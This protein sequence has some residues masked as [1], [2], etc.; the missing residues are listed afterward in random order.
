MFSTQVLTV[1]LAP[2]MFGLWAVAEPAMLVIFGPNWAYA[3]PVLGLLALS[4]AILTPCSTFI[5]YLK[6]AGYGRVLFWSAT[7]RALVTTGAVWLAAIYGTLIDAMVAL[8]V[9]NAITLIFYSWAVFK[10][11]ETPLLKGLY[12]SSRPM[13]ASFVMAL[14]VRYI[15]HVFADSLPHAYMQVLVGA[16]AGG[17]IYGVL[18]LLTER[19]LLGKIMGLVRNRKAKEAMA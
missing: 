16:V 19:A 9:V 2:M 6:G 17:A 7:I 11:S 1:I 13:I 14:A 5:P 10:A 8:C 18:I 12:I 15:L 3:W 4:K